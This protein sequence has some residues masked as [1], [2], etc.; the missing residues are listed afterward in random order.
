MD[1]LL[2]YSDEINYKAKVRYDSQFFGHGTWKDI[3]QQFNNAISD[4]DPNKLFQVGMDGLNV[5]LKFL[6][7][8]QQVREENQQHGLINI[9]SCGLQTI[10]NAFK[11]GA[12]QTDWKMKKIL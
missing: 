11:T 1:L 7:F 12:E 2:S 8:I 10:H 9:G 3:Q 5:S 4:L 6:Q